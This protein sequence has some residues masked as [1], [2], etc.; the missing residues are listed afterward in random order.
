MLLNFQADVA[1]RMALNLEEMGRQG[2]F[3]SGDRVCRELDAELAKLKKA[4]LNL[5]EKEAT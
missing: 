3:D 2:D 5:A 1:A 4:L